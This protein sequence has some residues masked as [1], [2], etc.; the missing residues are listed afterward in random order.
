MENISCQVPGLRLCRIGSHFLQSF[1]SVGELALSSSQYFV[2]YYFY[3][4]VRNCCHTFCSCLNP[5]GNHLWFY[6]LPSV[7]A[8]QVQILSLAFAQPVLFFTMNSVRSSRSIPLHTITSRNIIQPPILCLQLLARSPDAQS[9][10]E[11]CVQQPGHFAYEVEQ[12]CGVA[13]E[14]D[15]EEERLFNEKVSGLVIRVWIARTK[16]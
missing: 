14:G 15:G 11:I 5:C 6:Q 3:P 9:D 1:P 7:S 16:R 2:A 10:E 4:R 13:D 8:V 12:H